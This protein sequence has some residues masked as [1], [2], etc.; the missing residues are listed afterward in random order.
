MSYVEKLAA[1][2]A[3]QEKEAA[4]VLPAALAKATARAAKAAKGVKAR[5]VFGPAA[6]QAEGMRGVKQLRALGKRRAEATGKRVKG[7]LSRVGEA[8]GIT[9]PTAQRTKALRGRVS[10]ER[11]RAVKDVTRTRKAKAELAAFQK[12]PGYKSMQRR[13]IATGAV[14]GV[15]IGA[16]LKRRKKR[17]AEYRA[18][19]AGKK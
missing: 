13:Q 4:G 14:G 11:G 2:P 19:L 1:A 12:T 15:L 16:A 6:R 10:A 7:Y 5:K 17:K 18:F 8:T 3:E 9:G